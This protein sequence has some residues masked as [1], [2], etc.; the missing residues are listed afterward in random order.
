MDPHIR[1]M[2]RRDIPSVLSIE[3]RCFEFPWTEAE[4]IEWLRGRANNAMVAEVDD[5]VV[6]FMCYTISRNSIELVNL[7][8][9]PSFHREGIGGVM[10]TK[11]IRKLHG[12]RRRLVVRVRE[13]NLAAQLFFK[14]M[15]LKCIAIEDGAYGWHDE[16][17]YCFVYGM[18]EVCL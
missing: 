2:I 6:G 14:A 15:D 4:L 12:E 11:L 7:A 9:D 17:A 16:A 10:V 8:V 5:C 18:N 3:E 13:T 1:W